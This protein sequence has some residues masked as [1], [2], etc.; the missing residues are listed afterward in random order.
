MES[1][2]SRINYGNYLFIGKD[3]ENKFYTLGENFVFR[4]PILLGLRGSFFEQNCFKLVSEEPFTM[5]H[6]KVWWEAGISHHPTKDAV[7]EAHIKYKPGLNSNAA[8]ADNWLIYLLCCFQLLYITP[9]L[10]NTK[11][12]LTMFR[13]VFLPIQKLLSREK[14]RTCSIIEFHFGR[15][16][17]FTQW[18]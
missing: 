7:T 2:L 3:K 1:P 12:L 14:L 18:Q 4:F 16:G 17:R 13:W 15:K 9:L 11:T 8:V 6:L 5:S 10:Y